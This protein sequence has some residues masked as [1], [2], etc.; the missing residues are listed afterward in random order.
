M[1]QTK[2][3]ATFVRLTCCKACNAS[4]SLTDIKLFSEK[5]NLICVAFYRTVKS[6]TLSADKYLRYELFAD[7]LHNL[8]ITRCR[9]Q[10]QYL[11]KRRCLGDSSRSIGRLRKVL[12][13]ETRERERERKRGINWKRCKRIARETRHSTRFR[14]PT[15]EQ[16][17]TE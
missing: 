11:L 10:N 17:Y 15:R 1:R 3:F 6:T 2:A 4:K 5:G 8:T 16:R 12:P 14:E 13:L 7:N 9:M